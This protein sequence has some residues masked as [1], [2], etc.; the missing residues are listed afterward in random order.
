MSV[1]ALGVAEQQ[2]GGQ[3]QQRSPA[4]T[5]AAAGKSQKSEMGWQ[6]EPARKKLTTL[7]TQR[8]MG[9]MIDGS[10]RVELLAA[11][12][13]LLRNLDDFQIVLGRE[14]TALLVEHGNLSRQF[15][16]VSAKLDVIHDRKYEA[17]KPVALTEDFWSQ[18]AEPEADEAPVVTQSK[19]ELLPLQAELEA[20]AASLLPRLQFSAR[21][22]LRAF[23]SNP[24][25]VTA[26]LQ[27]AKLKPQTETKEMLDR[28]E[29]LRDIMVVRLMTTPVEKQDKLTYLH[30][31]SER[32]RQQAEVIKKLEAEL[33]AATADKEAEVKKKNDVIRK[34]QSDIHHVEKYAEESIKNIRSEAEKQQQT[35]S[36]N[37][38]GKVHKLTQERNQL[39]TQLD[40]LIAEH[41]DSEQQLRSKKFKLETEIENIISKYDSEMGTRQEE[42]EDVDAA[43]TEEKKQLSELEERFKTLEEEYLQIMEERRVAEERR[44]AAEHEMQMM[45]SAA[46]TIQSFWR[47]YK[48]RKT[49]RGKKKKA[50]E[51]KRR[52]EI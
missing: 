30:E 34:I 21:V 14:L 50:G 11:L 32:E 46:T 28:M 40:N 52:S 41:R 16:L 20:E 43:Y 10:K 24:P 45:I 5:A 36:K 2:P 22:L 39:R 35:D 6:L 48:I 3:P 42:Y 9:V 25:A 4:K 7:E 1:K 51:A 37:S 49:M 19:E 26:V 33:S 8:I 31:M 15:D 47:S 23:R 38:E 13:A 29:H 12:P 18:E 44:R 27:S 17:P